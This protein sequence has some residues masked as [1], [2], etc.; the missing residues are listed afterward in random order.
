MGEEGG[1]ENW[2]EGDCNKQKE[3]PQS[4]KAVKNIRWFF[5]IIVVTAVFF[6]S[7]R[8]SRKYLQTKKYPGHIGEE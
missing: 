6:F 4:Y 7:N 1:D 8:C 2:R 3:R 5:V